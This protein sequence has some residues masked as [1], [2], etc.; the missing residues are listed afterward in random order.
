MFTDITYGIHDR[1]RIIVVRDADG[2]LRHA[3]GDERDR[4]NQIYFPHK[5]RKVYIILL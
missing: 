4:L 3:N 1:E 5:G 2:V